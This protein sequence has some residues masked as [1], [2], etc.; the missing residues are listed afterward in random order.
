LELRITASGD[1]GY[2]NYKCG[3]CEE[4]GLAASISTGD[5]A[6]D[7]FRG[8]KESEKNRTRF[9]ISWH[10]MAKQIHPLSDIL[11]TSALLQLMIILDKG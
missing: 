3:I 9:V 8:A 1:F 7:R 2:E 6:G 10:L 4:C 5:T 11:Q